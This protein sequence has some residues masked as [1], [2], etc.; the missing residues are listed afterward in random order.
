MK[1]YEKDKSGY[2]CARKWNGGRVREGLNTRGSN[3]E[4]NL[5]ASTEIGTFSRMPGGTA[6]EAGSGKRA[7]VG[8]VRSKKKLNDARC[9]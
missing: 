6:V 4:K 1:T 3:S 2:R 7:K 9:S 5:S 8:S